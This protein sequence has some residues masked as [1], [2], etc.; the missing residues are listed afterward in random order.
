MTPILKLL[1]R[2]L[3][4]FFRSHCFRAGPAAI[5]LLLIMALALPGLT[6]ES[7]AQTS[8]MGLT[9][10]GDMD[11][12]T[13]T[14][15]DVSDIQLQ[16]L[17]SRA[18]QEGMSID[19][20]L[21]MA[22]QYGL[23]PSVASQ[24]RHRIQQ[25]QMQPAA[26]GTVAGRDRVE[27]TGDTEFPQ[28]WD[29]PMGFIMDDEFW[30]M[31]QE[32]R[33]FGSRL[34]RD[35]RVRFAP[36]MNVP[37]PRN[38]ELGAGDEL[39]IDVW[40]EARSL[41]RLQVSPEGTVNLENIGPVYVNGMTIEQ[42]EERLLQ[43]LSDFYSGLR[44][45]DG[46]PNT[47]AQI[48]LGQVRSIQ[49]SMIGEVRRPGTYTTSSLSTIFNVLHNAGGPDSIGTYRDIRLIRDREEV[50][51]FDIYDFLL[52][53]NQEGNA[54][55][56]DGDVITVRPYETQVH[57]DGEIKR[58]GI[59]EMRSEETLQD[60]VNFAGGFASA[61]YTDKINIYRNTPQRRRIISVRADSMDKVSLVNGDSIHIDTRVDRFENR[62]SIA[63]AVWREG[64]YEFSPGMSLSRLIRE[65]DGLRPD[66]YRARGII[67]RQREDYTVQM[68]AFDVDRVLENP[69]IYDIPLQPEDRVRIRSLFDMREERYVRIAGAVQNTGA[70]EFHEEMTM[71]DLIMEAGGFLESA[72]EARIEV[73]RRV[74]GDPAAEQRGDDLAETF[75][76]RVSRDLSLREDDKEFVLHPFDIVYVRDNPDFQAQRNVKITG[77]VLYPGT[78]TLRQR[79]ER[80]SDLLE[81]A[82]GLTG[83]AYIAGAHMKRI[84]SDLDRVPVALDFTATDEELEE[85]GDDS[86]LLS[87]RRLTLAEEHRRELPRIIFDVDDFSDVTSSRIGVDLVEILENPGSRQ[88]LFLREGDVINI[89]RQLQT[90]RVTGA[91]MQEVELRYIEGDG[92]RDYIDRAGGF[93][94]NAMK[95]RSYVIYANGDVER[96]R[97][98]VFG[99]I[100]N[101]PD[102][103]PGAEIIIPA[104]VDRPRMSTAEIMAVSSAIVSM[105]S[106]LAIAVD[107]I[108]R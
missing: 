22:V 70:Y 57:I 32:H 107:R 87:R 89:P 72:S 46:S 39:I 106:T 49:V 24:L 21:R 102:V 5:L 56:K 44:P 88:D 77:E 73:A 31:D 2:H 26:P 85:G 98:Y 63:G 97:N 82:G 14:S 18:E 36:V 94:E 101:R 75:L 11:P 40:G 96:Q 51:R 83:E 34:F 62:V 53:G 20:A 43:R 58:S 10:M 92:L 37:T 48:S 16:M 54:R 105:A 3:C 12:S 74:T 13:L 17:M 81:R 90:V 27:P 1:Y 103:E 68:V 65:A 38:Y 52:N 45:S 78:Y 64:D 6:P 33:I 55:V 99:L 28:M 80:I 76:F 30:E 104:K 19:E 8:I 93:T 69:A 23:S 61:A 95:R 86:R 25:L 9:G 42:A 60:L 7:R 59:Y 15:E 84:D 71:E 29:A 91:V 67:S 4:R 66:A 79:N 50:A 47:W 100:R 41:H 108:A 35:R